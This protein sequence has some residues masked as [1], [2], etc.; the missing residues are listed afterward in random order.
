MKSLSKNHFHECN[1]WLC[2]KRKNVGRC[3]SDKKHDFVENKDMCHIKI[4]TASIVC[5]L[6]IRFGNAI[7]KSQDV[8]KILS[9]IK[10]QI[11]LNMIKEKQLD[12]SATDLS[13]LLKFFRV[14]NDLA[15]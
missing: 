10:R 7:S 13:D 14:F 11:K 9:K 2:Y 15:K 8:S 1:K 3:W 12:K 6:E 5:L 4:V